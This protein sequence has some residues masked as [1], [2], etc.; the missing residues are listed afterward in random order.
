M[1]TSVLTPHFFNLSFFIPLILLAITL[2][3]RCFNCDPEGLIVRVSSS[4][5]FGRKP[6]DVTGKAM[7]VFRYCDI[8]DVKLLLNVQ[9]LFV[10][11]RWILVD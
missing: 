8:E 7:S 2:C 4:L 6:G 10:A 3:A 1:D 9:G 5:F 11:S